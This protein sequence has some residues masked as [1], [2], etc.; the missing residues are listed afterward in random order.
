MTVAVA[1]SESARGRAALR[2]AAAEAVLH[3]E[4]LAVLCIIAG[5]DEPPPPSEDLIKRIA[6]ELGPFPNL[7]WTI[8]IAPEGFDTAE[9][10]LELADTAGASMLVIGSR[11]RT[12]VGKLILGSVVQQ[13]LLKAQLPVLVVKAT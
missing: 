5:V 12:P 7:N 6:A 9:A 3:G 2:K 1:H 11:R 8:H 13:V 10:L 4:S